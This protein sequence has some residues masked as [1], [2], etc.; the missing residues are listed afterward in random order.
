MKH[1]FLGALFA[2][3]AAFSAQGSIL[4][5]RIDLETPLLL[6]WGVA[7]LALGHRLKSAARQGTTANAV[8]PPV[9]ALPATVVRAGA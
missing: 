9:A 3:T 6:V 8:V 4:A 1:V 7:L 5:A 2:G